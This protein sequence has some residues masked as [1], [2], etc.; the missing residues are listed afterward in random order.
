M[1]IMQPDESKIA[2]VKMLR[3]REPLPAGIYMVRETTI[4]ETIAD[5]QIAPGL[6]FTPLRRR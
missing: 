5:S 1:T 6:P 3:T 2:I 4:E